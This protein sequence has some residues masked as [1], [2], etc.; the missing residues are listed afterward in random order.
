M[1]LHKNNVGNMFLGMI[2][3]MIDNKMEEKDTK[4]LQNMP[5][6]V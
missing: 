6:S 4:I 1:L 3:L 5:K 2:Y